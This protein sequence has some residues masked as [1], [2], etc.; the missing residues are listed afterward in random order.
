MLQNGDG[1]TATVINSVGKWIRDEKNYVQQLPQLDIG[2][3]HTSALEVSNPSKLEV[4][5]IDEV[6][7]FGMEVAGSPEF[8]AKLQRL[9]KKLKQL[10][11]DNHTNL[12]QGGFKVQS[13]HTHML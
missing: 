6:E 7:I 11:T 4:S 1:N 9:G 13:V 12:L 3:D 5:S 10:I 2:P 8:T